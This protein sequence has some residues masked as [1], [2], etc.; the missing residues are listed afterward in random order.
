VNKVWNPAS[1]ASVSVTVACDSGAVIE[2]AQLVSTASPKTWNIQGYTTTPNCTA[3]ESPIPAGYTASG[4]PPGTCE[5]TAPGNCTITNTQQP[6]TIIVQKT[7]SPAGDPQSFTVNLTGPVND[8]G[9]ITDA[10]DETFSPLPAGVY[11]LSEV[12]PP[13]WQAGP[14]SCSDSSPVNA[15]DLAAGETVT[16]TF[17]NIYNPVFG[18]ASFQVFKDFDDDSPDDVSIS[19]VCTPGA[20]F[21]IDDPTASES[22][23]ADFTVVSEPGTTC[24]ASEALPFGYVADE[25]GCQNVLLTAGSCTIVNTSTQAAVGGIVDL[26]VSDGPDASGASLTGS[27]SAFWLAAMVIAVLMTFTGVAGVAWV[28]KRE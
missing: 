3:T 20:V 18:V 26:T 24:T 4:T 14:A 5:G 6:G 12:L 10:I 11:N 27:A 1:G 2:G 23:P 22:D 8:T 7:T 25:S 19:L 17:E 15:I 13:D 16:C 9:S 28:A 21:S